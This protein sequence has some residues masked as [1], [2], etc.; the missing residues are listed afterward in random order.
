MSEVNVTSPSEHSERVVMW[1]DGEFPDNKGFYAINFCW[2]PREGSFC[3]SE[4]F[5]G[6]KWRTNYPVIKY[7]GPF[8]NER[9]AIVFSDKNDVSW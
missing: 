7:A 5:D 9:D 4:Y 6:R 1:E 8:K 2:E 3:G